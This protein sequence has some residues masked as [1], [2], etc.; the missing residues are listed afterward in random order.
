MS[1]H[2]GLANFSLR[3]TCERLSQQVICLKRRRRRRGELLG[4]EEV[5]CAAHVDP[6]EQKLDHS[7]A[8]GKRGETKNARSL[9]E[10]GEKA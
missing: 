8:E 5:L 10:A 6:I 3:E 1:F 7:P 2:S 9:R 4:G